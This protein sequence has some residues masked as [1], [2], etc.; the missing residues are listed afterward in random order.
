MSASCAPAVYPLCTTIPNSPSL[1]NSSHT[2]RARC[3]GVEYLSENSL[4]PVSRSSDASSCPCG[5]RI[6]RGQR[7]ARA[8]SDRFQGAGPRGQSRSGRSSIAR[9]WVAFRGMCVDDRSVRSQ[10]PQGLWERTFVKG[11]RMGQSLTSM[12]FASAPCARPTNLARCIVAG[13]NNTPAKAISRVSPP[14][15]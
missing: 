4:R 14:G 11:K 10:R 12:A 15:M 3:G 7:P 8:F 1:S 6:W 5:R 2:A 9:A 13:S